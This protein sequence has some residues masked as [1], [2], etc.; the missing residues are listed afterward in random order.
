MYKFLSKDILI[1][2]F[3]LL[4]CLISVRS[5]FSKIEPK[6]EKLT[7]EMLDSI[8]S[9]NL[10][11]SIKDQKDVIVFETS[12]CGSCRSLKR[13]LSDSDVI[14]NSY[15]IEEDV[16]ALIVY[17]QLLGSRAGPVPVVVVGDSLIMGGQASS[18]IKLA[19][20]KQVN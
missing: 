11:P 7:K 4:F 9:L 2:S 13:K 6:E 14:Y 1:S 20:V 17:K 18:I 8:N 3:I 10:K 19:K 15:D 16:S 12:W 5:N